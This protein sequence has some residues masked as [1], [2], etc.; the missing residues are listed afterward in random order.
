MRPWV[1]LLLGGLVLHSLG[2]VTVLTGCGDGKGAASPGKDYPPYTGRNVDL[3]DDGID[4]IAVGYQLDPGPAPAADAKLRERVDTGE[5]V[6]RAR[7]VTV[8]EKRENTGRTW[9]LGLHTLARLA[10]KTPLGDDFFLDVEST[11]PGAGMVKAYESSLV[12]ASFVV[13]VRTF[14]RPGVP[15]QSDLHFHISADKADVL[16]AVKEAALLQ[17]VK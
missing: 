1:G 17:E 3:F 4:P 13:A 8:T 5:A 2:L 6:V 12:G 11:D 10:G 14:A 7:V 16:A 15:G 9:Q